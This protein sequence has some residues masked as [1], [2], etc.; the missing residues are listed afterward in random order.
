M[1]FCIF[2]SFTL[3]AQVQPM[4]ICGY[5]HELKKILEKNPNFLDFQNSI[6]ENVSFLFG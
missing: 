5:D 1:Y 6:F 4:P 3:N 2:M